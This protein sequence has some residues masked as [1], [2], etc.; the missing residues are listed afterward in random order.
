VQQ[1][2]RFCPLAAQVAAGYNSAD[3]PVSF[4]GNHRA[5]KA[6]MDKELTDRAEAIQQRI[7]QL[8]DS[9]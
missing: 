4:A 3:Q 9:L 5:Q 1:T 6:I 7:V 8:R 2:R